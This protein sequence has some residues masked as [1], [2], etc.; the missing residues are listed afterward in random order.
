LRASL[1]DARRTKIVCTIGPASQSREQ[2]EA[3]VEAGMDVARL[4]FSHG[5]AE[6]HRE[7]IELLREICTERGRPVGI[8]LDSPGPKLRIGQIANGPVEL[9]RGAT[10]RF[11]TREVPGSVSEVSVNF[12]A[13][14]DELLAGDR[15][16][17]GDGDV[18]LEV[19]STGED[20][21]L[22]RVVTG[23]LLSSQKGMNFPTRT[24]SIPSLTPADRTAIRLAAEFEVDFIALSFVRS[25]ADVRTAR[26]ELSRHGVSI[27]LIAKIE[28]HE[29]M[30]NLDEILAE[31]EGLLVARG[32]LAVDIP[33]EDI[34]RAQKRIIRA[35]NDAG[36]P[37]ITAT[38]M[39]RSM[40]TARRPTRAE[41]TDV[42][43]ALY[44]GTDA[45]MLSEETAIGDHPDE[46][47]NVMR[48]ICLATERDILSSRDRRVLPEKRYGSVPDVVASAATLVAKHLKADALV[49]PTRTGSTAVK[50]SGFRP[51]QP[52]FAITTHPRTASRLSISWGVNALLCNE[53]PTHESMLHEAERT[54]VEAGF[55]EE[56][57]LIVVT[58]GF[59][60]GGPGSTNTLTVKA[61][62]QDMET[63]PWGGMPA[64]ALFD[65]P[66]A[67]DDD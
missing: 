39:L 12:G 52:I 63:T 60:V 49:V 30:D 59:P 15:V 6:W 58:A 35:A 45:V 54:A 3:L 29:A 21:V 62:G 11:L 8:L 34:P 55:L 20:E 17:L 36:K 7:R 33:L 66:E 23:G 18:E 51:R 14:P 2:L 28:K 38:Q 37:V 46:V 48:R 53:V 1:R 19:V 31:A 32:D 64:S 50:M 5:S 42:A 47:V 43:N 25:A 44:D 22:T 57:D 26:E 40:V 16:F 56:G 41:I 24:L 4:N 61:I 27:P 13:L 9:R 65:D 10:F 67:D